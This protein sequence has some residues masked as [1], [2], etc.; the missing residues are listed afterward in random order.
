MIVMKLSPE[1]QEAVESDARFIVV[2]APAGSGK[3]EVLARR[4]ERLL[5]D[6]SDSYARVLALSYTNRAARE[7]TQRMQTVLGQQA[8]RVRACTI[9]SYAHDLLQ[10]HGTYVGLPSSF[11]V[12]IDNIDKIA[13]LSDFLTTSGTPLPED[14]DQW[15]RDVDLSRARCEQTHATQTWADA[16]QHR[17]AVDYPAM[18]EKATELLSDPW[19]IRTE[20]SG[21]AHVI[22]DEAQNL[23]P[24]QYLLLTKLVGTPDEDGCP[25]ALFGDARQGIVGF[26]GADSTLTQRF[27]Q[28][29]SATRFALTR[30]YRSARAIQAVLK[31]VAAQL[32]RPHNGQTSKA[33]GHVSTM[34]Y[35]DDIA[36]GNAVAHLMQSY[37]LQGLSKSA[38]TPEE[39]PDVTWN[40]LAVLARSASAL[41]PTKRSLEALGIPVAYG[42]APQDWLESPCGKAIRNTISLRATPHFKSVNRQRDDLLRAA[43]ET[44]DSLTL[45]VLQRPYDDE[46]LDEFVVSALDALSGPHGN[47]PS[48]GDQ[49]MLTD[50]HTLSHEWAEYRAVTPA[51]HR[52]YASFD[53]WLTQRAGALELPDGVRLLTVHKAQSHQFKAVHIVGM[54]AGTFPSFF[55]QDKSAI[56]EEL[57][58]FYV[59]CSRATRVLTL[60]WPQQRT[61]AGGTWNTQRSPFLEFPDRAAQVAQNAE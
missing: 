42:S 34:E 20:R 56:L 58:V 7:L 17:G 25:L 37:G 14:P 52:T 48:H 23:T 18:I 8:D 6:S 31:L 45:N 4:I 28:D 36:E 19:Q 50:H 38:L 13:C 27:A 33:Q 41:Q 9:H 2:D 24:S 40:D 59:A 15:F 22:V 29:Y 49:P 47:E 12:L 46:P 55:A 10:M 57:S 61:N 44:Q 21:L 11:E 60:S 5:G 53:A 1:Q 30:N 39:S 35:P 32:D 43:Q 51:S 54:A 26:A 3:T 16:L